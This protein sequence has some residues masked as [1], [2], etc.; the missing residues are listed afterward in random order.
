MPQICLQ[1]KNFKNTQN[2]KRIPIYYSVNITIQLSSTKFCQEDAIILE[3]SL[4]FIWK[5]VKSYLGDKQ[6]R[7]V[8]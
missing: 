5:A 2:I 7:C 6:M 3:D 4:V 8:G 1:K